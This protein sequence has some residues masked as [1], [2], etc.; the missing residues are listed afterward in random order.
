MS[1]AQI[2]AQPKAMAQAWAAAAV[3]IGTPPSR[4]VITAPPDRPRNQPCLSFDH[5]P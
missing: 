3:S 1:T 5:A 4:I 2:G